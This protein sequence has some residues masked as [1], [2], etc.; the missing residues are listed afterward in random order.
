MI[1][2]DE[3]GEPLEYPDP[4]VEAEEKKRPNIPFEVFNK[5]K[6]DPKRCWEAVK[7]FCKSGAC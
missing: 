5:T 7:F 1:F 3:R 4:V 6:P 2:V